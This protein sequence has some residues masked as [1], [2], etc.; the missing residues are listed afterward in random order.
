MPVGGRCDGRHSRPY[1]EPRLPGQRIDSNA[2]SD[3]NQAIGQLVGEDSA[4]TT[5]AFGW[6]TFQPLG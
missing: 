5:Y 2:K 1:G 6:V 3:S 4:R